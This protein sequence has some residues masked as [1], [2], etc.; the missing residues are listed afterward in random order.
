MSLQGTSEENTETNDLIIE[1][2][3]KLMNKVGQKYEENI[4]SSAKKRQKNQE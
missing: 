4:E 3:I 2:A 1:A